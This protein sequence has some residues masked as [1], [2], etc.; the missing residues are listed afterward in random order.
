MQREARS[1]GMLEGTVGIVTGAGSGIGRA[2]ALFAARE[3]ARLLV[4]GVNRAGGEDTVRR[5]EKAGGE[6]SFV[7]ADLRRED[8]AAAMVQEAL[9]AFGRLDWACN[10]A[11]VSESVKL[12]TDLTEAEWD[13]FVGVSLKGIWLCMKHQIPA[14]I[15][16]GGGSIVNVG[17]MVGERGM[18]G[19]S[20]YAAAKGGLIALSKTAA[21]EFAPRG[22]RVNV[23]NAGM[24]RTPANERFEKLSPEIAKRAIES[25]AL[26]R[27]GEPEEVAEMVIWLL[28]K[29]AS[30][31]TGECI[32]VDGGSQVKATTFPVD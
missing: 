29:R 27:M 32:A 19:L 18:P 14:M 26:G 4:A 16:N 31:V 5:I 11:S 17:S 22:I 25:H 8:H 2:T 7:V 6:A 21:A 13:D 9:G 15:E 30:F 3:G 23:V 1:V 28:S 24:I 10:S 20:A 12:L